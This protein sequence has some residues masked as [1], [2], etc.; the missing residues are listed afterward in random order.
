M[1][2]TFRPLDSV[3]RPEAPGPRTRS[4]VDTVLEMW[5]LLHSSPNDYL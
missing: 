2:A 4:S 5:R 3:L 1:L